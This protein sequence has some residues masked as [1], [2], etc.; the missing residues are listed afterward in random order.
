[1]PDKN[2]VRQLLRLSDAELLSVIKKLCADNN[3][4]T[5]SIRLGLGEMAILR[6]VLSSASD[7]DIERFL[8]HL[9][10]GGRNG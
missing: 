6:T 8:K 2:T 9:T 5:S 7:A 3:I 4:D 10:G 1:M